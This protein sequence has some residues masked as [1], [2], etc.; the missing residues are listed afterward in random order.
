MIFYEMTNFLDYKQLS[1]M[2]TICKRKR[3]KNVPIFYAIV[4]TSKNA[5]RSQ[6]LCTLVTNMI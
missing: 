4:N 3:K 1:D 5:Q 6:L 2:I